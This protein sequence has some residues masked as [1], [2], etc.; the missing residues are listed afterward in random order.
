MT[1]EGVPLRLPFGGRTQAT[2][3]LR[4]RRAKARRPPQAATRPGRPAPTMG[5]GTVMIQQAVPTTWFSFPRLHRHP[6]SAGQSDEQDRVTTCDGFWY[7]RRSPLP[8][9]ARIPN[10]LCRCGPRQWN[11]KIF[12]T[13]ISPPGFLHGF[14]R[15][16]ASGRHRAHRLR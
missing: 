4:R 9:Q 14:P 12:R 10:D 8:P 13:N 3:S 15:R 1:G 11:R 5:P 7:F 2:A 6:L 16:G